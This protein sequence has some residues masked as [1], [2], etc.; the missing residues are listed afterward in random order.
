MHRAATLPDAGWDTNDFADEGTCAHAVAEALLRG[1]TPTVLNV[2]FYDKFYC[3]EMLLHAQAYV[4]FINDL[5]ARSPGAF[6][7][8]E[9]RITISSKYNVFGTSDILI[10]N[11]A[12]RAIHVI[13]LK[14]G[15]GVEVDGDCFQLRLYGAG[16]LDEYSFMFP[17]DVESVTA[18]IYQPRRNHID[19][20]R[21]NAEW[22]KSWFASVQSNIAAASEG[23]GDAVPGEHCR[24]CGF[25]KH[26]VERAEYVAKIAGAD[27]ATFAEKPISVL[28]SPKTVPIERLIELFKNVPLIEQF[29]KDVETRV[30]K[31]AKRAQLPGLKWV[32]GRAVRKVVSEEAAATTLQAM[33]IDPYDHKMKGVPALEKELKAK[34]HSDI[35]KVIPIELRHS[36]PVLVDEKDKR[37][38]I[39]VEDSAKEDFG[40]I[41]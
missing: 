2:P 11:P 22:L 13:D 30:A 12:D 35:R 3:E 1:Q 39:V 32:E 9:Q 17:F 33:G 5:L 16:A 26:C 29:I 41:A 10:I 27:F 15:Q 18:T 21:Y 23:V 31:E 4:E 38:A 24:W 37:Q 8:I 40:E 7:L 28:P 14:Y 19:S 25:R 6:L 34:G 36:A 20:H